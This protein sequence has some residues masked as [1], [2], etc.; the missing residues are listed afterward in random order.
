[1]ASMGASKTR[2]ESS[3]PPRPAEL[4]ALAEAFRAVFASLR[5]LRGR[6]THL[7]RSEL[8]H[9]QY[10]LL[11]EL[12][13]RGELSAGEL[14]GA[15]YLTPATVTQMLDHLQQQDYVQ[16]TR[17]AV[18]RR[19]VVCEL[20]GRGRKAVEDKRALWRGRWETALAEV[21]VADL[22]AATLVLQRLCTVFE[23]SSQAPSTT[24]TQ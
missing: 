23:E 24:T 1:M 4:N 10:E 11:I 3:A 2:S 16:R 13:E 21:S 7:C 15:A 19:V 17:S 6:D 14:A 5:R 9:A 22:Q 20:T 8:S 12:Y 18:D